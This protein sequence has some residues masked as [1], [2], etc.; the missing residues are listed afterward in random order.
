VNPSVIVTLGRFSFANFFPKVTLSNARGTVRD[1]KGIKVLPVYHPAAA[2]YNPNLK[3]KLIR[4]FQKITALVPKKE[5][6]HLANSQTQ[7]NTQLNL[8]E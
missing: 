1:W 3:P 2:L 4:D 8:F 6:K 7:P 5:N